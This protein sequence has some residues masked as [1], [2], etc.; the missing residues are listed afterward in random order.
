[1]TLDYLSTYIRDEDDIAYEYE[2]QKTPKNIVTWRRY[3]DLWKSQ[4]QKNQRPRSHVL[5][6]YRR[7]SNEFVHDVRVW[8]EYLDW[9]VI[10]GVIADYREVS[11][12]FKRAIRECSGDCEDI[13]L[14]FLKYAINQFDLELIRNAFDIVLNKVKAK[15]QAKV[16]G[17]ILEFL[18]EKL[19]PLIQAMTNED[20]DEDE[21]NGDITKLQRNLADLISRALTS[22]KN[23]KNF[24]TSPANVF[25]SRLLERY[26]MVCPHK[27][28]NDVLYS[29]GKTNDTRK[30]K[31]L[32]E[33]Y[34]FKNSRNVHSSPSIP[35]SLQLKYLET[36][37]KLG[38][39]KEFMAFWRGLKESFPEEWI[40]LDFLLVEYYIRTSQFNEIQTL[41]STDLAATK[42]VS[43]FV[44]VYD[45]YLEFERSTI[46]ETLN[47]LH[48]GTI[49]HNFRDQLPEYMDTLSELVSDYKL[50]LNDLYLRQNPNK[51][52]TWKERVRLFGDNS[53][54][55]F[56]VYVNAV[57]SIDPLRVTE[58]G[59]FGGIWCDYAQ[60]YWNNHDYDTAREVYDRATKVPY[61]YLRDLERV[62]LS[63]LDNELHVEGINKGCLMLE[64]AL[65][66]PDNWRAQLE[67][68]KNGR[69]K[70]PAQ[71]A[72]F[73]SLE[74]WTKYIDLLE[75]ACRHTQSTK[76]TE[77]VILAYESM[78]DLEL[79]SPELFTS[80]AYFIKDHK[81][82]RASLDDN[83]LPEYFKVLERALATFPTG[84]V[85]YEIW[86]VY[87]K[88]AELG[89]NSQ[90]SVEHIRDLFDEALKTLIPS[91]I[92][93]KTI[94]EMYDKFETSVNNGIS[95]RNIDILLEGARDIDQ[96]FVNSK[97]E[98][99][100]AA[101]TK[102][103]DNFGGEAT[104]PLY[105]E[106]IQVIPR[107]KAT[108]FV[109][110]FASMESSLGNI[111]R[112]REIL[113]YGAK[114][115]PPQKN[116]AL[117]KFWDEFELRYG[118]KETYRE[119]LLLKRKLEADMK[120]DTEAISRQ[121][122]NV[123]FVASHTIQ[124]GKTKNEQPSNTEEIDLGI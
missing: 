2:L 25:T 71:V 116:N 12:L 59:A 82:H 105:E 54:E 4:V 90:L 86:L 36:L 20:E 50:K 68:F 104:R 124:A 107:S 62:W 57:V 85:Q 111:R 35:L 70:V 123:Q 78:I 31:S 109:I 30:I 55:Q 93:C 97:L 64:T 65:Q 61:P 22:Q 121:P 33:R 37:G 101:I 5:W 56:D 45:F 26:L 11:E 74:L 115:L 34:L 84:E 14:S 19:S 40:R 117:W 15:S 103:Q 69:G 67:R 119:M 88:E 89:V 24:D 51:V 1:M 122:G 95:K 102:M 38:L 83:P 17:L 46:D 77:K 113:E 18:K 52:S 120:I 16:W 98:L 106:C 72:V 94:F 63:W 99:W 47:R 8:Q 118:S 42:S 21:S 92:D 96:K 91:K 32:Y 43:E 110:R 39:N 44:K 60:L 23:E 73:H 28:K 10:N 112:A 76:L 3:L 13:C 75:V 58:P 6:L 100:D 27:L 53:P 79:I 29:L 87:L 114:L 80:Y 7:L 81:D 9:V 41:L 48:E 49:P 108:K 66:I